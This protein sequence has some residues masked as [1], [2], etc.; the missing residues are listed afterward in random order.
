MYIDI[1]VCKKPDIS[2]CKTNLFRGLEKKNESHHANQRRVLKSPVG[3]SVLP[4]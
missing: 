2:V 4:N 3:Y 1:S